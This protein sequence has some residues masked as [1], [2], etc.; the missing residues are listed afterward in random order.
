[1][2]TGQNK[3]RWKRY[4][5]CGKPSI[6]VYAGAILILIIGGAGNAASKAE[7][8]S[9]QTNG[10]KVSFQISTPDGPKLIV[11]RAALDHS[12]TISRGDS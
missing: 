4:L 11:R 2:Q 6:S 3:K 1:M 8:L 10:V 5:H 7:G 12:H 9:F